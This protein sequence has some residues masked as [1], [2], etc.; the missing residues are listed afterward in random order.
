MKRILKFIL[1]TFVIFASLTVNFVH[2]EDGNFAGGGVVDNPYLINSKEDLIK[3]SLLVDSV[4]GYANAYYKVMTDIDMEEVDFTP[5]GSKNSFSGVLD[6][7]GHVIF[8][9]KINSDKD[10][11]GLISFLNGG[12]VKNLGIE[13]GFVQGGSRTGALAGRTMYADIINC[14]SKADVSGTNDV[15]GIVGM[16][17]NSTIANCYVWGNI[18]GSGVTVGGIAGGANRSID[19][20]T[21]TILKNCYSLAN[22]TGGQYVGSAIGYDESTAGSRYEI[23]MADIYY[24]GS[25]VGVGNNEGRSGVNGIELASFQDGRL[26][27]KLNSNSEDG[28]TSWVKGATGYPEFDDGMSECGLIGSG[29]KN[30]P[31]LIRSVDDL[32]LMSEIINNDTAY[33]SA[34]YKL[35]TDLDMSGID[36]NPITRFTGVFDGDQ[37]YILNLNINTP[38]IENTGLIGFLNGGTIKNLGIES[39]TIIGGNRTGALVGRTMHANII[40]CYSKADVSGTNDVG[41]IVG[42]F[43]NSTIA[44]CYVWGNISGEVT[45]GGIVGGANRS[46]DPVASTVLDNC[47]SRASVVG[48]QHIGAVVGYDEGVHGKDYQTTMSNLYYDQSQTG[49]G[50]NNN[51]EGLNPIS[52]EEFSNG[53]LIVKL[54]LN[55]DSDYCTWLE[56]NTGYPGFRGKVFI[57]TSLIG[58]GSESDPYLIKTVADLKE[59]ERVVDLSAEFASAYYQLNANLDLKGIDFN[60][61]SSVIPFKGTFDGDGHVVKNLNIKVA[62]GQN[63]GFFHQVE[64]GKIKNFG[65][66]SGKVEA[67]NKVGALIG[68]SMQ[69]MIL[70]CYNNATVKG[71]EDV[72]GIVGMLNNS[73]LLNS[74]NKGIVSGS[75]SLGGLAGSVCRSINPTV[76]TNITN[77][78]NLGRVHWGTYSGKIAGYI[79]QDDYFANYSHVYYNQEN[80]PNVAIGNLIPVS[81]ITG[82]KKADMMKQSFVDVLNQ[83]R[84]DG[85]SE[86]KLGADN[87]ARLT[88]FDNANN[89]EKFMASIKNN[90]EIEDGQIVLPT[91]DDGRYQA[92][93]FGSS[94]QQV[95]DLNGQ[96]YQPLTKQKVYLIYNIL[97]TQDNEIVCQL[98]RNITITIDGK[99]SDAGTNEMPNVVPGLREWYGLNGN[100]KLEKDARIIYQDQK[101]KT[102]AEMLQMY[103]NEMIGVNLEVSDDLAKS[104]DIV[105]NYAPD[106]LNEL[107]EEGYYIN[108]GDQVIIN[109]PNDIGMLYGS[110]SIAQI[111]YQD[112]NHDTIPMGIIRDYPQYAVRGGM[113]DVA[114]RYFDLDYIEEMGK[115]MAWFKMNTFHLHINED[116]GLGGE[117][118]S[119]FVVESKKYPALNTYNL[120]NG[121]YVWSQDDYRQ[122]QKNLK[123]FGVNVITEID[124]P[125]HATIFNLINPE[126]VN[127]SNFDLNNHYDE[128][129]NL[130]GSV[131]DEFL[132]G[133]DPVFQNAA[134]HIGTD[135]SSNTNENMRRYINDL[136]QYC[137]SKDNID[138]VYFWGNL[139]VYYGT[140]EIDS[141]NVV[142][143]IWDSADQRVEQAL[144]DGFEIVNSTSNSMYL[145]PGN[146]NGLHNGY[147]DM[148]TFYNTWQ[149]C[150]DF[151]T[152]R[153]ANP[154][155]IAS[156]NYYA[157]YDLL[158]GN[159]QILGTLFC[160]WNDR[161]WANDFD[162]LDLVLSYIGVI[163]EKSWYG[164]DDRFDNGSDFVK[165]FEQVGDFAPD[166]NPRKYVATDSNIIAK[167]DFEEMAAQKINDQE[168]GYDATVEEAVLT[169][170]NEEYFNGKV[171]QLK[172]QSNL[173][174]PFAGV[175]YPYTV[176]FD[177]YLNGTQNNDA[178]LFS[179][180]YC[181]FYLNYQN[182]GLSFKV[183]KYIYTYDLILPVDQWLNITLT[184]TYVHGANATTLLKVDG[185]IYSPTLIVGPASVPAHSMTSYLPTSNMFNGIDGYLDNLVIGNKYNQNLTSSSN[186][187]F[188]GEG[189]VENPYLI[190]SEKELLLFANEINSGEKTQAHFKLTNDLD[191]QDYKYIP[192][193]VFRGVFDGDGHTITN[194]TI[195][196]PQ[197]ENVG[198]IGLLEQGT[199][200]NIELKNANITGRTRVGALVGRTMYAT[201]INCGVEAVVSGANDVGGIVGMFNNSTMNNCYALAKITG[202]VETAGGLVGAANRSID[203][204]TATIIENC[205]SKADV[206]IPRF[207]GVIA[208]YDESVAGGNYKVTY[209]NIYY[210]NNKNALGNT[211]N[212]DGFISLNLDEFTNGTLLNN[213]NNNV[214]DGYYSWTNGVNNYPVFNIVVETNKI[215]LQIAIE[216][217]E[218]ASLENVVPAVV[219]E[220]NAALEN[221]QTIY[222]KEN[223]TQK[224][225]D[226]AFSRLASVM[227][228]L[229]FYKGDKAALQ[230][231]ADQIAN[232]TASE[233]IESTWNALQEVLPSVNDVLNNE[234]AMQDEIDEVYT[235]L[236]KAFVNLRL[237]PSKDLL[238]DLINKANGLNRADY[239]SA[240]LKAVD[241]EVE[242]ATAVLNNPK[243]SQE[244]VETAVV[245]LTKVLAGLE[246]NSGSKVDTSTLV[247]PGDKT[248][249]VKTGD[250]TNMMYS[251]GGLA[252]ASI[253]FYEN[254]KRKV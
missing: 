161:S 208:G 13:S 175:G 213:L 160:N 167:Y 38:S 83:S 22:V 229:E 86:W 68:R 228:M 148:E 73:D 240:S 45:V 104:G 132:D 55:L 81:T 246:V 143:Q 108:I 62:G 239:T 17:N 35:T 206:T 253:I 201:I 42:M 3:M 183:G 105:I 254:K 94:N 66:D 46:I 100:F 121:N 91:S 98:D 245:E 71:F 65:I 25:V 163:S 172:P 171:L 234:N 243:A 242:K 237:K 90:P 5:I 60:G 210:E 212:L 116:S 238:Q 236:V 174:L 27:E 144:A 157:Q 76:E 4:D 145:I 179:D 124:S 141:K 230:K 58:N 129:L 126:I 72:G 64:R 19:P 170:M 37:H 32:N 29:T 220:F 147:V 190:S 40:N 79:E 216:M 113:L 39:G 131:F 16:F 138:K 93:L 200:K 225:V 110:V 186:Y 194:L 233:Y 204:S 112:K 215:A 182:H 140:E 78:Y 95:I 195:N 149:G 10:Q 214:Q 97:D 117:Y 241:T 251:L 56:D 193:A 181:T 142:N 114:R 244:E 49:I 207:G 136:A 226:D 222:A 96:I 133:E 52:I 218:N 115:Y 48:S 139:S 120:E 227:H 232:L 137:L 158:R 12:T 223:A 92:V 107:K 211:N 20:A 189:T 11:V 135:E 51:R 99:Y 123:Q 57:K 77:S 85:Y 18:N 173:S 111:L 196:Q 162:V 154:T 177:L 106:K 205:Y 33:E 54:N 192:A 30:I 6:G 61:L 231:M 224:E 9:L 53:D 209:R 191:M 34:Y 69:A 156:R 44:N 153:I 165:A 63:I 166:A 47:Y 151:N 199:I 24:D 248:V 125:G 87:I 150:S 252:V 67:G 102:S 84:Q 7:N 28:Y 247:K 15:G 75:K 43:N 146:G 2:G 26:L 82:M 70:N 41:G 185:A 118:S 74:Y 187:E 127:G 128:C 101:A 31:Y 159:P 14:Y 36:F 21:S 169:A 59:M 178:I 180:D 119:S 8:N 155:Y 198:L 88:I 103:L 202:T 109:A 250:T 1:C 152:H 197:G 217:A 134:V 221:A 130:I 23:T 235:E 176:N 122:M 188:E 89:L 249:S 203:P 168:N 50:N 164:D 219:E 80:L 184:S